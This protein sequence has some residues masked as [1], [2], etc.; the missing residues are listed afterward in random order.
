MPLVT[1]FLGL[2]LPW[3]A[4]VT[5]LLALHRKR[6]LA[7]PGELAWTLGAGY[8]VGIFALTLWMRGLSQAGIAFGALPVALPLLAIV[9]LIGYF[10]R[11][12]VKALR[13]ALGDAGR[14]LLTPAGLN[15]GERWAWRALL[16]WIA[17]RFVVL[18]V[19]VAWQPLFPWN[20]WTQW[21]TKA[22]VWYELGRIV[23]FGD[24]QAWFAA[25][26]A[27]YFDAA[28][29]VPPTLPLLQ[30]WAS[31][32]LG[33]WDDS[34]M[35]WPWWQ[36]AVALALS[37]YGALR[38]LTMPPLAA[39]V[40]AFLVASLP[41]ANVHVAF[42]GYADLPLAACYAGAVLALLRWA[43]TRAPED[44]ATVVVLALGCTQIA[45]PGPAWAATLLP[46]A[47]VV[48]LPRHGI[49]L[50]VALIGA[51]LFSLLV[52]ELTSPALFGQR[53]HLVYDPSWAVLGQGYFLL[54]SW[55]LLSYG[56]LAVA[57]LA[58]RDLLSP[59]LAPLTAIVCAGG[60][61]LFTLL[62]FSNA[63]TLLAAEASAGRATLQFAPVLVVFAALAFR[64][65]ASRCAGERADGQA[66]HA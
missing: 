33:R 14:A 41:L 28:P 43:A 12:D 26:G 61:V 23:P 13:A 16:L 52:L 27:I 38:T 21:A 7:A 40:V 11:L 19:D 46:A 30:V 29:D 22:R 5:L 20:A 24:T 6:S 56:V 18:A 60:T 1:L 57:L 47:I 35:N 53:L 31:L 48:L 8:M 37:V 62:A 10:S 15:R 65:F 59:R 3:L 54:G 25:G 39:L 9:G 4:G 63:R 50:A 34:L 66:Q 49:K 45:A 64:S 51:L 17:V 58:S 2:L 36:I 32:A 44:A 42:A 55:N